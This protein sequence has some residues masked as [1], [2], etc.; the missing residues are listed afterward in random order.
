MYAL[1]LTLFVGLFIML[2]AFIIFRTKNNEN[3]MA[4]SITIALGV[5]TALA[6][7]ELFPESLETFM[8][9]FKDARAYVLVV[10]SAAIG[11]GLLKLLDHFIPDH[12]EEN[13][14]K[15][16]KKEH[17][18]HIGIVASI[19]LVIHNLIEGM[20]LYI[21]TSA[22]LKMGLLM[23]LGIGLHNI[24]MGMVIASTFYN[25]K[26]DKKKTLL[27]LLGVSLS[28]FVG[29]LI[30]FFINKE[31][32]GNALGIL[33]GITLGMI[34]YIVICELIP[35]VRKME[36]KKRAFI[37]ILIGFAILGITLFL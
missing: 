8:E 27:L 17:L 11:F 10:A 15:K 12:E 29:G 14:T 33:L 4:F 22:D 34:L 32:T 26:K 31:I 20:T 6:L 7:F 21:T 37:G 30:P 28:T 1:L 18:H 25:T 16:A 35:Q 36:N 24:P 13:K 9:T 19:A 5:M 23:C 2:G 3:I